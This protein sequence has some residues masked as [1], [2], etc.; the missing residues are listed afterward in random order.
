MGVV[1]VALGCARLE[2]KSRA[3]VLIQWSWDR[4]PL[5]FYLHFY[6]AFAR[7]LWL[8]VL[9][10]S[11]FQV[12][13]PRTRLSWWLR[14]RI[15]K[16]KWVWTVFFDGGVPWHKLQLSCLLVALCPHPIVVDV[17][18]HLGKAPV[19]ARLLRILGPSAAFGRHKQ[20]W[21]VWLLGQ[22]CFKLKLFV[23]GS[24]WRQRAKIKLLYLNLGFFWFKWLEGIPSNSSSSSLL[25]FTFLLRRQ[26]SLYKI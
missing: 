20:T 21:E 9:L 8:L 24:L 15:R 11:L 12:L 14:S 17:D 5:R 26:S 18:W 23:V 13:S 6:A 1:V 3:Q 7:R 2:L 19:G 22:F 16:E 10:L 25:T 4:W